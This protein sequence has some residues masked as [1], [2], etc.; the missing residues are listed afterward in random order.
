MS[1]QHALISAEDAARVRDKMPEIVFTDPDTGRQ[2][3]PHREH[4]KPSGGSMTPNRA[5][6]EF[7]RGDE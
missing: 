1:K 3:K 2:V 7:L 4:E 6:F 5:H